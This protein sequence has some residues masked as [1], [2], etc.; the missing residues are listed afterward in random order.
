MISGKIESLRNKGVVSS[1]P[2]A[3]LDDPTFLSLQQTMKYLM[4]VYFIKISDTSKRTHLI[5]INVEV[6]D[7]DMTKNVVN[8]MLAFKH[9]K[10]FC[11][12][13]QSIA[14]NILPLANVSQHLVLRFIKLFREVL[15]NTLDVGN[16]NY[17]S[18]K[19]FLLEE[20]PPLDSVLSHG[21]RDSDAVLIQE[22]K[23]LIVSYFANNIQIVY[24][25]LGMKLE[26]AKKNGIIMNTLLN[27]FLEKSSLDCHR[28][29]SIITD[30][31]YRREY[32]LTEA[33]IKYDLFTINL[34]NSHSNLSPT[35]SFNSPGMSPSSARNRSGAKRK[36]FVLTNHSLKNVFNNQKTHHYLKTKEEL[37]KLLGWQDYLTEDLPEFR[38]DKLIK[39]VRPIDVFPMKYEGD[40]YLCVVDTVCPS[41][42]E[43]QLELGRPRSYILSDFKISTQIVARNGE[44]LQRLVMDPIEFSEY[45]GLH[46]TEFLNYFMK[47]I[48][49][50]L[51]KHKFRRAIYGI[52]TEKA[53]RFYFTQSN[54]LI[55]MLRA[56]K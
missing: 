1:I 37:R 9:S 12:Y 14:V 19:D 26:L 24:G 17:M 11:C 2:S 46:P 49:K 4:G 41:V 13:R 43:S 25:F 55:N 38:H 15:D 40:F 7:F 8:I 21:I 20:L 35:S 42:Q 10:T 18:E 29:K 39:G 23:R 16:Y 6:I 48:I 50:G 51:V 53:R 47:R 27:Y 33:S 28:K 44:V 30:V 31:K 36:G 3:I 52:L 54:I 45:I 34:E 56:L 5:E 32:D 22:I